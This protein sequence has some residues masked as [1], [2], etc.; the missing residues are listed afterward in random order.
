MK[1]ATTTHASMF[2]ALLLTACAMETG[3]GG[4]EDTNV[5]GRVTDSGGAQLRSF[6]GEGTVA[7]TSRVRASAVAA[8]GSLDLLAEAD[9]TADGRY[10]I[11]VPA[12]D[13]PVVLQA[14]S[15]DGEVRAAALLESTA[16]GAGELVVTPMD[17]ESSLEA[18][19]WAE[20]IRLDGSLEHDPV[21][22]RARIDSSTAVAVQVA[23]D[24][25]A[26][27]ELA[28]TALAEAT[29]A[30]Q[31]TEL[32]AY[33]D[34]G[35]EV[36]ARD[37]F[38]ASLEASR[39]LSADLDRGADAG[40]SYEA[41]FAG[42]ADARASLG[43]EP[44]VEGRAQAAASASFR[45]ALRA[46]L[47]GDGALAPAMNAAILNAAALEARGHEAAIDAIL[48]AGA[49]SD[50]TLESGASAAAQLRE[51]LR[52]AATVEA[53]AR[54][55]AELGADLRGDAELTGSLLGQYLE[56]DASA[57]IAVEATIAASAEATATLDA[58]LDAAIEAA[59]SGNGGL[60]PGA[61]ARGVA[62]A[63]ATQAATLEAEQ[64]A[65]ATALDETRARAA[66]DLLVVADGS[67]RTG[68]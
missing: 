49:A 25:G 6:G 11:A 3:G 57:Q 22:L 68:G 13:G 50:A 64:A 39:R 16:Q 63:Y 58:E 21:D 2:L 10:E 19:V 56:A 5:R 32:E 26:D 1:L 17:S 8:D 37:L 60:E 29:L 54:A 24:A 48:R 31:R 12:S 52:T 14:T 28:V 65:L 62:D 59:R 53:A 34:A 66:I 40:A 15:A 27:A 23:S 30:A 18:A 46:R 44:R 38:E 42:L 41:F 35:V 45:A 67:F 7:A 61:L 55:Y 33:A 20:M 9:V 47:D 36:G 4:G 43:V 51:R